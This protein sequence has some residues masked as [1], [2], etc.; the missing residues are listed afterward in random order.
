[1]L[2]RRNRSS[3]GR[4]S[5]PL[6]GALVL[7]A[8]MLLPAAPAAAATADLSLTKTDSPDPVAVGETFT[9]TIEVTNGGP[10]VADGSVFDPLPS[11]VTLVE[12]RP[13][14][15]C[16]DFG[17]SVSC[18]FAGLGVGE[19]F[20]VEIDVTADCVGTVENFALAFPTNGDDPDGA[21]D[22]EETT[23]TGAEPE[24]ADVTMD[25][26][27]SEDPAALGSQLV[28]T[29]TVRN[30]GPGPA[31]DVAVTDFLPAEVTF[32]SSDPGEPTCVHDAGIVMCDLGTLA[33]GAEA[34]ITITVTADELGEIGNVGN[35]DTT[36]LES[37]KS[38]NVASVLTTVEEP[39]PEADVSITKSDSPDPAHVGDA[40][41]Y[42]L[43][44]TNNGP[45]A[46]Q[47]VTVT[48][49]LPAGVT[50]AS[51][52][53]GDP[54]CGPTLG[55]VTC[56]LGT[57][58]SGESRTITITVNASSVGTHTNTAVVTSS[59]PTDP[60]LDN[61]EAT[62]E[63]T[64]APQADL[65][66]EKSDSD[67]P[68][69]EGAVF[70]YTVVVTN[71]GPDAAQ[72]VTVTDLLP[73]GVSF[74]SADPGFPDCTGGIVS[75]QC[76][77]GTMASGTSRT[78][79][80]TVAA[81]EVGT[82]ENSVSVASSTDD[83]NVGNNGDSES[84]TVD[85]PPPPSADVRVEKSDSADPV[86]QGE[87]FTYTIEVTNDGPDPAQGVT[88]VDLLPVGM[89]FVSADPGAPTCEEALLHSVFCNLGTM[90][91]GETRSITITVTADQVGTHENSVSIDST[92]PLDPQPINDTDSEST[93]V[94]EPPP[95]EADVRIEKSDS[96]DPVI[97][98]DQFTYTLTVTNDGPDPAANVVVN[99]TLPAGV[100]FV[101]SSPGP[102][103]CLALIGGVVSCQLGTMASG[104]TRI[105]TI[106]VTADDLGTHE[107]AATVTSSTDDPDPGDNSDSEA[108]TVREAQA[109]VRVEKTDSADPVTQGDQFTYT[110]MVTN[111][112]PD[113]A[114][115]VELLDG[116]PDGV[117]FVAFD[118]GFLVCQL[119]ALQTV[120]CEFGTIPAGESRTI[121]VRVTA[122]E[123][124]THE[125]SAL[126]TT[127][128]GDPEL[129][130]NQESETTTVEEPPPPAADLRIEKS[131]SADPVTQGETFT[132][133]IV[134]TNDGPGDAQDVVVGDLLPVGVAF[135]SATPLFVCSGII[136]TVTCE[137][138]TLASGG[139]VTIT[140]TVRALEAG[141]HENGASVGSSTADPNPGNNSDTESTTV[142][143]PQAD[144]SVQKAD[145]VDP[146]RVGDRFNYILIVKNHG[147]DP[148]EN[149]EVTDTLPAGLTF[150]AVDPDAPTC[151]EAGGVVACDLGTLAVGEERV[152]NI[153]VDAAELGT[154]ENAALASSSTADPNLG[155]NQASETTDVV[156]EPS[157]ADLRVEKEVLSGP[158][159]T[160]GGGVRFQITVFN[161]GPEAATGVV[162]RDLVPTA[163]GN[164]SVDAPDSLRCEVSPSGALVTCEPPLPLPAG[165]ALRFRVVG[166]LD[167]GGTVTNTAEVS[168]RTPDPDP[169]DNS[170]SAPVVVEGP[171]DC[172]DLSI[173]K[174]DEPDPVPAGGR[175][176]Y[177]LLV[178]NAGPSTARGVRVQDFPDLSTRVG[179]MTST[180][181]SC[182]ESLVVCHLGDLEPGGTVVVTIPVEVGGPCSR[183]LDNTARV[184]S[185]TPDPDGSNNRSTATTSAEGETCVDVSLTKEAPS[186][187]DPDEIFAYRLR[188]RN[189]GPGDAA[190]VV[191]RDP[192]PERA[193]LVSMTP[194]GPT[195][196]Q[197]DGVVTC[198]FGTIP[199]G[200]T[201]SVEI[202]VQ[203]L[204][205]RGELLV[206]QAIVTTASID[207]NGEND[208]AVART[209]IRPR[210]ALSIAKVDQPDPVEEGKR[211]TYLITVRNDG[212]G[213]ARDVV[214]LDPLSQEDVEL[215]GAVIVDDDRDC[216]FVQGSVRCELREVPAGTT[217]RI[218]IE[219]IARRAGLIRNRAT[220]TT[221]SVDDG[222]ADV[223]EAE[224]RVL[225]VV[226]LVVRKTDSPD[227][228]G[229]GRELVY[230]VIVTNAGS[231]PANDVVLVDSLPTAF[232][233]HRFF[234]SQGSCKLLLNV[235]TCRLGTIAGI[236]KARID[237]VGSS[238][239][240]GRMTNVARVTTSSR[241]RNPANNDA[242]E[243]T[244][245]VDEPE[246]DGPSGS[247]EVRDAGPSPEPQPG[248]GSG[249]P[250]G[251]P[252]TPPPGRTEPRR[253]WPGDRERSDHHRDDGERVRARATRGGA[254]VKRPRGSRAK[255]R[256][257]RPPPP[258]LLR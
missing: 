48:D 192:L 95:P 216:G 223:A 96:A 159:H 172:A 139:S 242:V 24:C 170:S 108:T 15:D 101:S 49:S 34:T 134:V 203:A 241:D 38:N 84:T 26:S 105:I 239:E 197:A 211:F 163:I 60:D 250:G 190:D 123:V 79:T 179:T 111:D 206:N 36:S 32:V 116:L 143:P 57:M 167:C 77:L 214:V 246:R 231:S 245:V 4:L 166:R 181:G 127:S 252:G 240:L 220:L 227:P 199:A 69:T 91:E 11:G 52:D 103:D 78:I 119:G 51:V 141:T 160:V 193:V 112:G 50:F 5:S 258:R 73:A 97:Q 238:V 136:V 39:P 189:A 164:V 175:L 131:D 115:D 90:E 74:V 145:S 56:L 221:S 29:L 232:R 42:T 13:T 153:T 82:H 171:E 35:V 237:I 149:V 130:D 117:S 61:N 46:A 132:Y 67:D 168:S 10:D 248:L 113:P 157:G 182:T 40:I 31:E 184:S 44:V 12:A 207:T 255:R 59:S 45:D 185:L 14:A 8:S 148:A 66:I 209:S 124:G 89:S 151:T 144:L 244:R 100:T 215:V 107:N 208:K 70:D 28:Y 58:A 254:T 256:Q 204:G 86:T 94:V 205:F 92:S 62:E 188:V 154:H 20:T 161:D 118:T 53:P 201:R 198:H 186:T 99:D 104:E 125:N 98:G 230:T 106:T 243:H 71:D 21:T 128:T 177:T 110:L 195:C 222:G 27:V 75:V 126:V 180:R 1:M 249:G 200:G 54:T 7:L 225:P 196:G 224:T 150:V 155:N 162:I 88:V 158:A 43:V 63:T 147:P 174:T 217:K 114:H 146:V 85:E 219:V 194:G 183:E 16:L 47:D 22:T 251:D 247:G 9:Y 102:P 133:T 226:D 178:H 210:V 25:K 135:L 87:H 234:R 173:L 41:T 121:V 142:Q 19:T 140:I 229:R 202:R 68:V 129:G 212:P 33:G 218:R 213:A 65:R 187:V 191:L 156:E 176:V 169:S 138:G 93:T 253:E 6:V 3:F 64:V 152:V 228:V 257:A 80:I 18:S 23:V 109:D 83:P 2:G 236:S 233:L 137:L 81:E 72:D 122:D 120:S 55:T 235:L 37:T 30:D 17:G 76:N 165:D